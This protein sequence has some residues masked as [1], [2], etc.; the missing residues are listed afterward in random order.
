[1]RVSR[2]SFFICSQSRSYLLIQ[3]TCSIY[4]FYGSSPYPYP[5]WT[6][7]DKHCSRG[8][9]SRKGQFMGDCHV[10]RLL[11]RF[12]FFFVLPYCP[13]ILIF[14][15]WALSILGSSESFKCWFK[16]FFLMMFLF[17]LS[18]FF[19]NK[20]FFQSYSHYL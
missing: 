11:Y 14:F 10:S 3:I 7:R 8:K 17:S 15:T 2:P 19:S 18:I 6:F 5:P 20:S 12:V 1:M 4:S 9:D 13:Q 16:I